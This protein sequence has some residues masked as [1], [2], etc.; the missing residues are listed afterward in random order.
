MMI[1]EA[2]HDDFG[3]LVI[4]VWHEPGAQR[5]FRARIVYGDAERE[6]LASDATGNPDEVLDAVRKWLREQLS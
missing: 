3:V 4:R 5:P 1:R 6:L 2:A